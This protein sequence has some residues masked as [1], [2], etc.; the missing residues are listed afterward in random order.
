MLREKLLLKVGVSLAFAA[1]LIC[2]TVL[3]FEVLCNKE[4]I[5]AGIITE[6]CK[7]DFLQNNI[8]KDSSA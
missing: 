5:K 3:S 8:L 4:N 2:C 1:A 7:T 6:V